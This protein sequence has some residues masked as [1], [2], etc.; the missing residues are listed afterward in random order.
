[1]LETDDGGVEVGVKSWI[2]GA[3]VRKMLLM[4]AKMLPVPWA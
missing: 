4:P 1:M 2:K 3:R